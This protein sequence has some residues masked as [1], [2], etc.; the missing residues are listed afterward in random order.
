MQ[1]NLF[2]QVVLLKFG[3]YEALFVMLSL[4]VFGKGLYLPASNVYVTFDFINK[5][6]LII[7][8]FGPEIQ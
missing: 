8:F 2:L 6:I 1:T 5:V 4:C 3:S 7:V